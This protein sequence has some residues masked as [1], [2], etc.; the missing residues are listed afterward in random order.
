MFHLFMQDQR[1][2]KAARSLLRTSIYKMR[3]SA[4]KRHF[5][6]KIF[7]H[8]APPQAARKPVEDTR[9]GVTRRDDYSWLRAENWEEVLAAP[10]KLPEDIREH[11]EAENAYQAA[12]M[13][14]TE[15]LQTTLIAE[16]KGR[17][18]KAPVSSPLK[19]GPFAYGSGYREGADHPYFY[20]VARDGGAEA[21]L[22]DMNHHAEG[23]EF[24]TGTSIVTSPDHSLG[25]WGYDDKGSE[26]YTLR[27]RRFEDGVD[28][29]E[30]IEKTS[31]YGYWNASGTGF[32]Y[33]RLDDSFRP[34]DVLFHRIGTDPAEDLL[35]YHLDDPRFYLGIYGDMQYRHIFI[36]VT[37]SDSSELHVLPSDMPHSP[38]RLI[39][40]RQERVHYQIEAAEDRFFLLT[41]A[42][43]AEDYKV[44]QGIWTGEELADIQE[45]VAHEPGRL[46][47]S[48]SVLRDFFIREEMVD[49][50]TRIVVRDRESGEEHVIAMDEDVYTLSHHPGLEYDAETILLDYS[51]PTTPW[52]EYE[53][54][55]RSRVRVLLKE[56]K[57]PSG[58]NPAHYVARREFASAE[59]GTLVPISLV[60]RADLKRDG[61]APCLLEGYGAYGLTY[62]MGF[63]G[64][65]LSLVDRGFVVAFAHVRGG[66]EKGENWY[67]QGKMLKKRNSF[68]DFVA[69]ARHLVKQN[70]TRHDRLVAEGA[71][72]GGLLMGASLN[73]APDAFA[74]VVA[75]YAFVDVLNTILDESLPL[76]PF[77]WLEWG[78]PV[79]DEEAFKYI[80]S[81]SPYDNL[82]PA[83]YPPVLAMTGI[84]DP[85]VGYWEP[86]KWIAK[87]R[88]VSTSGAPALLRTSMGSGHFGA[89]GRY[90]RLPDT[91]YAYAFILKITGM[92]DSRPVA[93]RQP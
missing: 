13:A 11:L 48:I 89:S 32:Y 33:V 38:P 27:I 58:H 82:K 46:I 88:E 30:V 90:G 68:S 39:L 54:N 65:R 61:S 93:P 77:E 45:V 70:Y 4:P 91:A 69:S 55:L 50:L 3:V 34:V 6:N 43:G 15:E 36:S 79:E 18:E 86:A 8:S 87:L 25:L 53:Y 57:I 67:R 64:A 44:V 59:D 76:T 35:I 19:R 40:P 85:R 74:G 51:S 81:Y 7:F 60:H 16:M 78:N 49:G 72:A 41:Q 5:M 75:K 22:I 24:F 2:C 37:D 23:T 26:F 62:P 73:L 42:D 47:E 31:G 1:H 84:A 29:P 17:M 56:Q 52:R 66:K 28:L 83:D 71:S 21:I 12:F 80:A 63:S 14:D 20:R 9:F 92:M 10:E